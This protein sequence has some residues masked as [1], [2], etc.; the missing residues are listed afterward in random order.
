MSWRRSDEPSYP[1]W[2]GSNRKG[3]TQLI[4]ERVSAE[5]IRGNFLRIHLGVNLTKL[6]LDW[7][8]S[9]ALQRKW[10]AVSMAVPGRQVARRC[11]VLAKDLRCFE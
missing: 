3:A 7:I 4:S 5:L 11:A 2:G 6:Y 1:A 10:T 9:R 8:K